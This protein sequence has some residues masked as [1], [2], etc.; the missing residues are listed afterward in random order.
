MSPEIAVT[1]IG[2]LIDFIKVLLCLGLSAL[3]HILMYIISFEF[4]CF[5]TL[6]LMIL[7]RKTFQSCTAQPSWNHGAASVPVHTPSSA[8]GN[9]VQLLISIVTLFTVDIFRPDHVV[10][11]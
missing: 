9:C 7:E 4:V 8:S 6:S 2:Y 3:Y 1:G 11:T 10:C 5:F